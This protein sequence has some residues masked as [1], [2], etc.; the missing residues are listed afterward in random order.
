MRYIKNINGYTFIMTFAI[1]ILLSVIGV[2]LITLTSS[3]TTKNELRQNTIQSQDLAKKGISYLT[4]DINNILEKELENEKKKSSNTFN[5]DTFFNTTFNKKINLFCANNGGITLPSGLSDNSETKSCIEKISTVVSRPTIRVAS[6]KSTGTINNKDFTYYSNVEFG[7][8]DVPE[9]LS[10]AVSTNKGGNLYFFGGTE[11]Q[12]NVRV[13]SGGKLFS[14]NK[15]F[16][17]NLSAPIWTQSVFPKII[18]NNPEKVATLYLDYNKDKNETA[19]VYKITKDTS[20]NSILT[21]TLTKDFTETTDIK[22]VFEGTPPIAAPLNTKDTYIDINSKFNEIKSSSSKI[23]LQTKNGNLNIANSRNE[24]AP[25]IPENTVK[26]INGNL[27]IGKYALNGNASNNYAKYHNSVLEGNYYIDGDVVISGVNLQANAILYVKGSVD[28]EF[29]TVKPLKSNGTLFVFAE[30]PVEIHNISV[31]TK[32][33]NKES[34]EIHGF[35]YSNSNFLM[36]GVGSNTRIHGGVSAKNTVFTALRGN[37]VGHGT[38]TDY[39]VDDNDNPISNEDANVCLKPNQS[40]SDSRAGNF[41]YQLSLLD[42]NTTL[43]WINNVINLRTKNNSKWQDTELTLGSSSYND[44][45]LNNLNEHIVNI[46][47]YIRGYKI[48]G[49]NYQNRTFKSADIGKTYY[50]KLNGAYREYKVE[51]WLV[52]FSLFTKFE[53]YT[54]YGEQPVAVNTNTVKTLKS[55]IDNW[56]A[57]TNGKSSQDPNNT[58]NVTNQW[59]DI[60]EYL[61]ALYNVLAKKSGMEVGEKDTCID[62]RNNNDKKSDYLSQGNEDSDSPAIQRTKPSR[63]TII[64]DHELVSQYINTIEKQSTNIE[65][66]KVIP[67]VTKSFDT[68]PINY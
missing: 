26:L 33:G 50:I 51:W 20:I 53:F 41:E 48:V 28:I 44:T 22:S 25:A 12:G 63:L 19:K 49:Q 13:A 27:N 47:D 35:F 15:A 56:N 42:S 46:N 38:T 17:S 32:P 23:N 21:K 34:S 52:L 65:D 57:N 40:N 37:S 7:L 45:F 43:N 5:I 54:T 66:L 31:D 11:I 36:Y 30:G 16:W 67:A 10:Y 4:S 2:S 3:G 39:K 6:I 62:D 29:S 55:L 59:N 24:D 58:F 60:G 18:S 14:Y 9:Q 1:L 64:Y 68:T 8:S 61:N